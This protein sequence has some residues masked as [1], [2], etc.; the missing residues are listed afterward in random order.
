MSERLDR[1]ETDI[2][3]LK[4]LMRENQT[5]ISDLKSSISTLAEIVGIHDRQIEESNQR[6]DRR[7]EQLAQSQQESQQRF[8]QYIERSE[9]DRALMLRLIESIAQGRNGG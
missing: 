5:Q 4:A 2:A 6:F 3:E 7:I 9:Q 8:D 1:V